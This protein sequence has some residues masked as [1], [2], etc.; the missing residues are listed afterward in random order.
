MAKRAPHRFGFWCLT[1]FGWFGAHVLSARTVQAITPDYQIDAHGVRLTRVS[2]ACP[3]VYDNDWWTDVP[4]AA[5]IWAKA[6]LQACNLRGNVI[7][8]CTFDWE[9][10]YAH[11]LDQ[12]TAEAERLFKLAQQSGL[13][14]VPKPVIGSTEAMRQPSSGKIEDT[15]FQRTEG[16]NLIVREARQTSPDKPLLVFVGG[17]CTTVAS[18]Y[19]SDPS[20]AERMIVFQIDGG[21]YNGSD[22]W[23]WKITM[24]RCRFA[25]WARGYFW[26]KVSKWQ[27]ERFN[28][29]PQNPLCEFLREYA[30][31]GHGKAN[32]WGDGA[33]IFQLYDPRCLT[34][35]EDY[36]GQ[37]IT[38]PRAGTNIAAMESEFFR[39]MT[40]PN[41]YHG[42]AHP[43]NEVR[44]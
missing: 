33:W 38:V 26:D 8:R 5:Y 11:T 37:A 12:Q 32:Q 2:P 13:K 35:A 17:S 16:S 36:D 31:R 14:N 29:L 41:A 7:T 18:A 9:K 22:Q 25:N 24:E 42:S 6:S 20:I 1:I 28:D 23:A 3:V 44:Q 27:P 40:D 19:L 15:Q 10:G 4:D 30:F 39:T 21:G 34:M 43:A